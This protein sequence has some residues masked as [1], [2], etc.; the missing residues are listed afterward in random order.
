M[1]EK[2]IFTAL[3][4]GIILMSGCTQ[5]PSVSANIRVCPGIYTISGSIGSS[6][7]TNEQAFDVLKEGRT[8]DTQNNSVWV[9]DMITSD[10]T[11]NE[12]LQNGFL[13][14]DQ[15]IKLKS[16]ETVSGVWMLAYKDK[17]I[18]KNGNLYLCDY[19][20]PYERTPPKPK[21]NNTCAGRWCESDDPQVTCECPPEALPKKA[22]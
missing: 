5:K 14:P 13:K 6:V 17:A 7:S 20:T 9:E 2:I 3:I 16:G 18:D 8:Y 1:R 4:L 21:Y 12:A 19:E 22:E 15:D 10:M 11:A